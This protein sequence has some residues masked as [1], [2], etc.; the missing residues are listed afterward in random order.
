VND[1]FLRFGLKLTFKDKNYRNNE[2]MICL[3]V[4][5]E[6]RKN[7]KRVRQNRRKGKEREGAGESVFGG[8][9]TGEGE[10]TKL[11]L[12][13]MIE[14]ERLETEEIGKMRFIVCT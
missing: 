2:L 4:E 14:G 10:K 3:R 9:R 6:Q 7:Y 8:R 1:C 11:F 5:Y 12:G 13:M